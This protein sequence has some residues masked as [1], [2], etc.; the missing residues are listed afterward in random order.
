MTR[1]YREPNGDYLAIWYDNGFRLDRDGKGYQKIFDG[2]AT[3]LAGLVGSVCSTG[4][5]ERF[6]RRCK[7]VERSDVPH[8][9][10]RAI[11]PDGV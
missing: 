2:R 4:I 11:E 6:R 1:Y 8:E 5:G 9:W 7:R 3:A 10:L